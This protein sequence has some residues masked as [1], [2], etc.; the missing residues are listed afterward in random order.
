MLTSYVGDIIGEHQ[1]GFQRNRSTIDQIL[2]IR[3]VLEKNESI[4][5]ENYCTMLPLNFVYI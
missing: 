4:M 2:S 3:P 1:C 5:G